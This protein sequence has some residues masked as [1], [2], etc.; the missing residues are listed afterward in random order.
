MFA[1]TDLPS[2]YPLRDLFDAAVRHRNVKLT[3][4]RCGHAAIFDGHAL[5]W[6][7]KRRGW[8]DRFPDVQRRMVC[9]ACFYRGSAKV[10]AAR[11]ELA[12]EPPTQ[13]RLEMPSEL[14]W[15]RELR[16]RR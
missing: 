6:L 15:K 8:A 1:M 7:F 2:A 4:Q 10:R 3:C 9:T 13:T 12:D 16:R 5:W 11:L 14:D